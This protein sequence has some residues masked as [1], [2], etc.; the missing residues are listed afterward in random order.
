MTDENT[1]HL[2]ESINATNASKNTSASFQMCLRW[3][4][5]LI[6]PSVPSNF[7]SI[8]KYVQ[9]AI[10]NIAPSGLD[11]C[12]SSAKMNGSIRNAH[13]RSLLLVK[14]FG[15]ISTFRP[16]KQSIPSAKPTCTIFAPSMLPN[17]TDS[18]LA[19]NPVSELIISGALAA[20]AMT[21]IPIIASDS[22]SLFA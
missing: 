17:P 12:P 11:S 18:P 19:K 16:T 1:S 21:T 6:F 4:F 2:P 10:T 7:Q 8:P 14:I 3:T 22:P 13:I 5:F 15:S 9:N 20:I